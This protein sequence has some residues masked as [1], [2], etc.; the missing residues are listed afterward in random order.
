MASVNAGASSAYAKLASGATARGD[1]LAT[2]IAA[3]GLS[4]A[5]VGL[6]ALAIL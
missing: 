3:W 5:A 6:G 2:S 4:F 1:S